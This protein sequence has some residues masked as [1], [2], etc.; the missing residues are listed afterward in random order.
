MGWSVVLFTKRLQVR[1]PVRE[2]MGDNQLMFL[3]LSPPAHLSLKS[4]DDDKSNNKVHLLYVKLSTLCSRGMEISNNPCLHHLPSDKTNRA[5]VTSGGWKRPRG[6]KQSLHT[7][8]S[9]FP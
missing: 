1:S 6:S 9:R 3:S 8:G 2:P 7:R 5:D 4:S